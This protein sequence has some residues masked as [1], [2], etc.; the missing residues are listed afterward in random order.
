MAENFDAP[1]GQKN[2]FGEV[3][4]RSAGKRGRPPFERTVENANKVL[5]LLAAGW[6]NERIAECVFDPR[7]G[8][9][10]SVKTLTRYFSPELKT[11][12]TARDRMNARRM[13]RLWQLAEGGNVAA[14]KLF[15]QVMAEN[16]MAVADREFGAKSA[17]Q[18][19]DK[20]REKLGK[21]VI[22]EALALDADAALME[23]IEAETR[24]N[25]RH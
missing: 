23:E 3:W 19:Q 15:G 25:V 14:E 1:T 12:F 11:R 10:I 5:M 17:E 21:K 18:P 8:M 4:Y 2:L 22:D 16:D 20:P 13:M 24:Q 7:T 6:V 9:S